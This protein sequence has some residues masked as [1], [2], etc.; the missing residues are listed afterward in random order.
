MSYWKT[1]RRGT[2]HFLGKLFIIGMSRD[3]ND[4]P[5]NVSPPQAPATACPS[6]GEGLK[7]SNY[8]F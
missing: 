3:E 5:Q 1:P 2:C 6:F 4:L 8:T 7:F